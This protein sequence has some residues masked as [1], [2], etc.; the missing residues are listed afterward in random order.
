[1]RVHDDD[2]D[3]ASFTITAIVTRASCDESER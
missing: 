1:M 3:A 2:A